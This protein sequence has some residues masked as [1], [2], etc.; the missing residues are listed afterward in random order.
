M[1]RR[2][3]TTPRTAPRSGLT[4]Q[5]IGGRAGRSLGPPRVRVVYRARPSRLTPCAVHGD[6]HSP[7]RCRASRYTVAGDS[8]TCSWRL[9]SSSLPAGCPTYLSGQHDVTGCF[10][11][12]HLP[13][14]IWYYCQLSKHLLLEIHIKQIKYDLVHQ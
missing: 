9:S 11:T 2:T 5:S 12:I 6:L 8:P 3:L 10:I 4:S 14:L 7:S 13:L 1:T